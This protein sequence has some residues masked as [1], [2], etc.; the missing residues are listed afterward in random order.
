MRD[1][2]NNIIYNL[3]IILLFE[4]PEA[5]VRWIEHTIAILAILMS[6]IIIIIIVI[7]IIIMQ[8]FVE[9]IEDDILFLTFYRFLW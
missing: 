7:I 1:G 8:I 2:W 3:F 4:L 5:I 9:N 6:S